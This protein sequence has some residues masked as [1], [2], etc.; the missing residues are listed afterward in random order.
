MMSYHYQVQVGEPIPI[1]L[2]TALSERLYEAEAAAYELD[3]QG[4]VAWQQVI[5]PVRAQYTAMVGNIEHLGEA[6][7]PYTVHWPLAGRGV[8]YSAFFKQPTAVRFSVAFDLSAQSPFEATL[9][10]KS[11]SALDVRYGSVQVL[12]FGSY[13]RNQVTCHCL[14][15]LVT[16]QPQRLVITA[17]DLAE[18]DSLLS[19]SIQY[20]DGKEALTVGLAARID[21][22]RTADAA[23]F[24]ASLAT[25]RFNYDGSTPLRLVTQHALSESS[26]CTLS[27]ALSDAHLPRMSGAQT[28]M[29]EAG[30]RTITIADPFV[31]HVGMA[32]LSLTISVDS[33]ALTKSLEFEYYDRSVLQQPKATIFERK[34]QALAFIALHSPD[35]LQRA[36]VL[37]LLGSSTAMW[38]PIILDELNRIEQRYDCSD[39]RLA[40]LIWA[41]HLG[42]E[43][44]LFSE[45]LMLR[46]KGV[47]LSY[48]YWYDEPG[49]DVMWFFSENHAINFHT[50]Q[51]LA[52]ALFDN[53]IFTNSRRTAREHSERAK[54]LIEAWFERFFANGYEEW[55]SSVYIPIDLIALLA[56]HRWADDQ[57]I[58]SLARRALD[59]TFQILAVN[60]FGGVMASS[61][62]RTYFK[63]LIGRRVGEAAAINFIA[64]GSG[65]LNH[66]SFATTLF[67]LS[68]YEP[69]LSV[70]DLYHVDRIQS[71]ASAALGGRMRLVVTKGPS[72]ILA[73]ASGSER[74]A[75]GLQEHL[76]QLMVG[77]P[78]TQLW[79]NHPGEWAPFGSGRPSYFAGNGSMPSVEHEGNTVTLAFDLGEAEIG[80]THAWV[81]IDRF[82]EF[83]D[84]ARAWYLR[85]GDVYIKIAADNGLSLT[86]S[87]P[88]ARHELV[89]YGRQNRWQL[90]VGTKEEAGSFARFHGLEPKVHAP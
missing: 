9:C 51:L 79:I 59:G 17:D 68:D 11:A 13:L 69:P 20:V 12:R 23:R 27:W 21:G 75:K 89:S 66:H 38:E 34:R 78:D 54:A 46:M 25:E 15:V 33:V 82:D 52:A 8:E 35:S 47:L 16:E 1:V 88:F 41:Y 22:E 37:A 64:F 26:A 71:F 81:P 72:F 70:C 86:E 3:Y 53:E 74:G 50:A 30:E 31:G 39:F 80:F 18:R 48:R 40:A 7:G 4:S 58:R 28:V 62:G 56:L 76:V 63:N 87:G 67:A 84:S 5:S 45:A 42:L 57:H 14:N 43:Q 6:S 44:P 65:Y 2:S 55:N 83:V 85:K 60:S 90:V 10:I 77:D 29:I 24:L 73:S 36:L 32:R 49:N 19:V 61:Y